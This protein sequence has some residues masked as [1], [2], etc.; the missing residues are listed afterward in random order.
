[1]AKKKSARKS[2]S[3]GPEHALP[4]GFWAQVGALLLVALAI[5]LVVTWF[6][7]SGQVLEGLHQ[8]NYWLAGWGAYVVPFV[9]IYLAV[10][11]LQSDANRSPIVVYL[12]GALLVFEFSALAG[13]MFESDSKVGGV[14]GNSF[15][16]LIVPGLVNASVAVFIYLLTILIT[17]LFLFRIQPL[18]LIDA[19][20]RF[21]DK[22]KSETT[23]FTPANKEAVAESASGGKEIE[24]TAGGL[25]KSTDRTGFN[26]AKYS[27]QNS[28]APA[29]ASA[30]PDKTALVSVRDPNWQAPSEDML[31]PKESLPDAGDIKHRAR[32]IQDTL[33]EFNIDVDVTGANVGPRVTQYTLV[34]SSGVKIQN[35]LGLSDNVA[36]N[37]AT[38]GSLRIEAPIPGKR[39]VGIEVPN[40]RAA[41][42]GLRGILE[43]RAWK[44][45]QDSLTFAVGRDIS[46]EAVVADLHDMPHVLVA[47]QTGAGKSVMINSLLLSLLYRNSPSDLKLIL[48][49]PKKVEMTAYHD[50]PHL[51]TPIVTEAPKALAAL[52]WAVTEMERRYSLFAEN[53]QKNINSYNQSLAKSRQTVEKTD[54][55]GNPQQHRHGAMPYIVVVVDELSDLMMEAS[56]NIEPAIVRLAQKGRAAGIH[57]VLATQRPSVDVVTGLI[58]ANVPSRIAFT[59]ASQVDSKTILDR[60]GAEKLL[61]KG[62]LLMLTTKITKPLRVQGAWVS[63]KEVEKVT[64]FLRSQQEVEYNDEVMAQEVNLGSGVGATGS[65]QLSNEDEA[66]LLQAAEL[67]I[68]AGRASTTMLQTQLSIGY[69]RAA[70]I[71][72]ELE[73]RGAVGPARGAVAREVLVSEVSDLFQG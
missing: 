33:K 19:I 62:D 13:L 34:P 36:L 35:I 30:A 21:I 70:R 2:K 63:D 12:A 39:A 56:K 5:L 65:G 53:Q 47:G 49:D 54:A 52:N 14:L 59:V 38:S 66:L 40:V 28:L 16:N 51:L 29:K 45:S 57:L 7:K 55:D 60:S 3:K 26:I 72:A 71:M 37:L 1:M 69:A 6:S 22:A 17:F 8:F 50:I 9:L 24:V 46:G 44:S 10:Q 23:T 32:V 18:A 64:D 61:G 11:I 68:D 73:N 20:R 41:D 58:K 48:I 15:N 31:E 4:T 27:E 42:V 43:S 25:A 67:V